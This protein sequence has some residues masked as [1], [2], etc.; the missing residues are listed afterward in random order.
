VFI[1]VDDPMGSVGA[2][3]SRVAH[4]LRAAATGCITFEMLSGRQKLQLHR[5]EYQVS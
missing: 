4:V 2:R 3:I 1:A 5:Q